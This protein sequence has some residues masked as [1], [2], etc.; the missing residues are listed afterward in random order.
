M[1]NIGLLAGLTVGTC[2]LALACQMALIVRG[3]R[4]DV[5]GRPPVPRLAFFVAKV[6]LVIS[7]SCLVVG[8][9]WGHPPTST[10]AVLAFFVLFLGGTF[11]LLLSFYSLGPSLRM[12]LPKESTTL[13]NSGIYRYS[14]NPI[15]LGLFL[16]MGAS[17]VYAFSLLN[18][19]AVVASV[20]I[21]HCIALSEERFLAGKFPEY[22][23][24]RRS[25][26]RYF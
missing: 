24:Y 9:V 10:I 23:S 4:I 2:M 14:R 6:S 22:E 13:V 12:G 20:I 16:L 18:L 19:A 7:T 26:R 8:I 11:V 3:R 15:Y 1:P 21:H 5:V 17:L 25:V